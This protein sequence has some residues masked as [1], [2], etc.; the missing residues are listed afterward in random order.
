MPYM[1]FLDDQQPVYADENE[2]IVFR[3]KD[4]KT[5]IEEHLKFPVTG[6]S[7]MTMNDDPEH[8]QALYEDLQPDRIWFVFAS[9]ETPE[10]PKTSEVFIM[11]RDRKLSLPKKVFLH[12]E[13]FAFSQRDT[14]KR[15]IPDLTLDYIQTL[16]RCVSDTW[17]VWR[18]LTYYLHEHK[19]NPD[20]WEIREVFKRQMDKL[21]RDFQNVGFL[22]E[23]EERQDPFRIGF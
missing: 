23:N 12:L 17:R 15:D 3:V 21:Y 2:S 6:L 5:L 8:L 7:L 4:F 9:V 10:G 1:P 22:N 19:D 14:A 18:D 11:L 20:I 16:E 13:T